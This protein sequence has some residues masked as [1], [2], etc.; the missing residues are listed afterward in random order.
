VIV[1]EPPKPPT[2]GLLSDWIPYWLYRSGLPQYEAQILADNYSRIAASITDETTDIGAIYSRLAQMNRDALGPGIDA[3]VPLLKKIA[4]QVDSLRD[5][6]KLTS[7]LHVK[8]LL[9]DIAKGFR[10]YAQA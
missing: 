7:A 8:S 3:W 2:S 5:E 10:S 6:G 4:N 1:K 9:L